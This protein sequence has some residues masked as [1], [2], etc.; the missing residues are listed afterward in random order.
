MYSDRKNF[1]GEERSIMEIGLKLEQ[2]NTGLKAIGE[3]QDVITYANGEVEVRPWQRNVI[4]KDIGKLV[5]CLFK[6]QSGYSGVQYWAIG[7]GLDSWDNNPVNATENDVKLVK[8]IG[9][10]AIPAGSI[11]F[12]DGN[13][14]V[15]ASVT[16]R[17]EIS[18]L[19][20]END[21]NGKWREFGIFGG[22]A[23]GTKDSGIMINHKVHAILTKTNNMTVERKIRFTFN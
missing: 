6:A 15:T 1:N 22:N 10:K 11:K 2:E 23:T 20:S 21:V 9:R 19:F 13:G 14:N 4:V 18:L 7:S 16:N 5:A 17:I 12:I 8:E 3:F